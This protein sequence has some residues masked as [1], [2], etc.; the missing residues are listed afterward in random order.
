MVTV[1]MNRYHVVALMTVALLTVAIRNPSPLSTTH[2]FDEL[3]GLYIDT[4]NTLEYIGQHDTIYIGSYGL[5]SLLHFT[6]AK[7]DNSLHTERADIQARQAT[8]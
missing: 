4:W 5:N 2:R 3:R 8:L 7:H 6:H 1:L